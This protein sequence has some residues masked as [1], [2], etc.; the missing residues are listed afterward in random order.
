M[1]VINFG[2]GPAMLPD[3]VLERAQVEMLDWRGTGMSIMEIGH[4]SSAFEALL[5]GIEAK[6]RQLMSI[7][8]NYKI[9]F[10]AGGAQAQFAA[11]PMNLLR[12]NTTADYVY[13]GVWSG[14]AIDEAKK[15]CQVN[16][17]ASGEAENFLT[18]PARTDW[19]LNPHAA[20]A[21]Y[22]PNE[23]LT[24]LQLHSI[25]EVGN[26]PLVADFTSSILSEPLE[27]AKFGLIFAS[28]QK[29]LGQSG[30]T[31]V[32]VREDLLGNPA[33]ITPNVWNY[34]KQAEAQSRVNT[35]PTYAI[36]ILGLML[37]WV[38]EQGGVT[39]L[40]A[41]NARKA[42]TLYG[43]IDQSDFYRNQVAPSYRSAMNVTFNLPTEELNAA[44]VAAAAKENL[45]NLKGH[46]KAGGIRVSLYNAVSAA[47][48][49]RLVEF[50]REFA[51]S[52]G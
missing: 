38:A 7:P 33:A 47:M 4:R 39:A 50:M 22:C 23:T 43:Y 10:L 29:N 20:Y 21:Y 18:I 8:S 6:L 40:A 17:V 9:L 42:R 32:I 27:V 30:V 34:T 2:A 44:F 31:T 37:D 5:L 14:L 48:V 35:P 15:H 26:V 46:K 28:A 51:K 1:R 3:S 41:T 36:Y 45:M 16:I 11:I 24:G 13:T 49:Q 52:A 19:R 25:P 12:G